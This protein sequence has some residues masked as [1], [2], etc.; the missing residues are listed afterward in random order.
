MVIDRPDTGQ[1]E[2]QRCKPPISSWGCAGRQPRGARN[3]TDGPLNTRE[4][5]TPER[6][7]QHRSGGVEGNAQ[8]TV[9]PRPMCW[10]ARQ[11][12]QRLST[13]QRRA[14]AI[15][16]GA[17]I[18]PGPLRCWPE[19]QHEFSYTLVARQGKNIHAA[20][21]LAEGNGLS[22]ATGFEPPRPT[23]SI[24]ECRPRRANTRK[25]ERPSSLKP[26]PGKSRGNIG[27]L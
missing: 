10:G 6:R 11:V 9:P 27:K 26:L 4:D 1:R 20:P 8:V 18:K 21:C 24:L 12:S 15:S 17:G 19:V 7:G 14:V 2:Q 25:I 16:M 3:A 23:T 13:L 5:D 22:G